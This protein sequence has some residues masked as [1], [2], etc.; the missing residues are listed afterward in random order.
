MLTAYSSH[1][2]G[3]YPL[4]RKYF[5][6]TASEISSTLMTAFRNSEYYVCHLFFSPLLLP[7]AD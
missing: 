2:S 1:F 6:Q 5:I 7:L 4:I 3:I